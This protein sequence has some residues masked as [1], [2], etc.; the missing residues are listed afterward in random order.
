MDEKVRQGWP[1]GLAPYGYMNVD[2]RNEP[3]VPHPVK[4]KTVVRIFE[5]YA[6]GRF[7]FKSLAHQLA[8]EGHTYQPSQPRF[9]RTALSYILNYRCG[10]NHPDTDH[11]KVRW[12]EADIKA[13]ITREL[14]AFRMP[15]KMTAD[16][17]RDAVAT[18][19]DDVGS[20]TAIRRKMLTKRRTELTNMQ[21]RL[22]NGYLA[23]SI[24]GRRFS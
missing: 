11:P 10:N 22:L 6:S 9:H 18:A 14:D 23:G 3:V 17:F 20:T 13:A 12:R 8:A 19:F 4:S 1:T 2:D 15:N 24:D 5:L 16:W 21:E 7:T